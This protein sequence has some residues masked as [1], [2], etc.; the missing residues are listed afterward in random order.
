MKTFE[1]NGAKYNAAEFDFNL[2]CELEDKGI[3]LADIRKKPLS[4][5]RI[6]VA[7]S[8]GMD[9]DVAGKEIEAHITNGGKLDEVMDVMLAQLEDSGF[10]RKLFGE[11]PAAETTRKKTTS[12]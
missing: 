8:S 9:I 7:L 5:I 10:F 12:K 2:T 11:E 3:S 6:Y 1:I 4:F